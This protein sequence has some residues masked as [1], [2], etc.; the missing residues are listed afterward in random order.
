MLLIIS[1][2]ESPAVFLTASRRGNAALRRGRVERAVYEPL[3]IHRLSRRGASGAWVTHLRCYTVTNRALTQWIVSWE[4]SSSD[5]SWSIR[6]FSSRYIDLHTVSDTICCLFMGVALGFR[7]GGFSND[8]V[9]KWKRKCKRSGRSAVWMK[10]RKVNS[11]SLLTGRT[12][13]IT[14]L[15]GFIMIM[16]DHLEPE[17]HRW[18]DVCVLVEGLRF[19]NH[20]NLL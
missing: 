14:K 1:R 6:V 17:A 4:A 11:D 19:I 5:P 20:I 16:S 2:A 12:R 10:T 3:L 13:T 7:H 15:P 8:H 9:A 18:L